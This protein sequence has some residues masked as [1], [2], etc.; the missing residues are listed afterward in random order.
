[1]VLRSRRI[2]LDGCG[3]GRCD[4][5]SASGAGRDRFLGS[6]EATGRPDDTAYGP[7]RDPP[8]RRNQE[9]AGADGSGQRAPPR[10]GARGLRRSGIWQLP[11]TDRSR[12][13]DLAALRRG[14]DDGFA[15]GRGWSQSARDRHWFR[16]P[17]RSSGGARL[18]CVDDGDRSRV[19]QAR[20]HDAGRSGLRQRPGEARRWL[21]GLAR[22]GPLRWSDRHRRTRGDPPT[23][24]RPATPG[25]SAGDSGGTGE[26]LPIPERCRKGDGRHREPVAGIPVRF[27]PLVHPQPQ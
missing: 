13:D 18:R 19:G 4:S 17:G 20:R 10:D 8:S 2:A 22:G 24:D 26:R 25:W 3:R 15:A 5:G 27:V 9:R 11:A 14:A 7:D 23:V 12:S 6:D 16:L 1:M 21:S